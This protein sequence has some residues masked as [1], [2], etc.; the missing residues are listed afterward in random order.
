MNITQSIHSSRYKEFRRNYSLVLISENAKYVLFILSMCL[1]LILKT[2][3]WVT[4]HFVFLLKSSQNEI[5]DPNTKS[6]VRPTKFTKHIFS[7]S[8]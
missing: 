8:I 6:V 1:F 4:S 5:T 7:D 3:N 2:L